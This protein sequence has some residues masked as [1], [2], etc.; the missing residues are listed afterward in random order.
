MSSMGAVIAFLTA[1]VLSAGAAQQTPA[2]T[3]RRGW[4]AINAGRAGEAARIFE[5]ALAKAPHEPVLLVGAATAAHLLGRSETAR[6][7]LLDA[8]KQ[9]PKF[10]PASLLLGEL[11][12]RSDDINGAIAVYDTAL[13]HAPGH[14]QITRKLE[15]WKKE[16]DL[17]GR[18]DQRFGAHF[19]VLFEG[20]AEAELAARAVEILEKA[21]WRLGAGL[22]AYPS[23]VITVVLYT[24]EQFRDITQS[25]SWAGGAFDGRIRVPVRGALQNSREFERVLTHELTHAFVRSIGG[26]RVPYWLDEGLAMYFDGTPIAAR[27]AHVQKAAQLLP[28]TRLEQSFAGLDD[29]GARLAYAQSA[30]AVDRLISVTGTTPVVSLLTDL[31]AG[32]PLATAFER[33]FFMT[34]AEFQQSLVNPL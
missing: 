23:D 1:V 2:A 8:L 4:E 24:Q 26:R 30:V 7:H 3:V 17:H 14:A 33:H 25:P 12:Y 32:V 20:P 16:A 5:D 9:D 21:Y 22:Y 29:A 13:R 34:Y 6:A 11:L 19:T 27:R 28:L 31:G 15:L 10:T 18:F